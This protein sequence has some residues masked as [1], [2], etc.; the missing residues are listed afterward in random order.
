MR[1]RRLIYCLT[2]M[3]SLLC[4]FLIYACSG[5]APVR[6]KAIDREKAKFYIVGVG[7]GGAD[8]ITLRAIGYIK[9]ADVII[10]G[11]ETAKKFGTYLEGKE[12]LSLSRFPYWECLE[13][14]CSSPEYPAL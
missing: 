8:L 5:R 12:I 7:A 4:V 9:R 14:K 10:C 13:R 1:D 6:G 2:I 3:V 11:E